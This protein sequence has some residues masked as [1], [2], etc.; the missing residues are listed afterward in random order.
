MQQST[1]PLALING[2][3]DPVSGKHMVARYQ[4]L[5]CRLDY[6]AQLSEIGHYPQVEAPAEVAAHYQTFLQQLPEV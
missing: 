1:I 2:S 6:L 3:V 4:E 5:N